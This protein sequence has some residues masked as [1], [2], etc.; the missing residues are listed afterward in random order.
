[1]KANLRIGA[2]ISGGGTNLQAVIDACE[3]HTVSGQVVFVGADNPQAKGLERAKRHGI[4]SFV[5]DYGAILAS[6][7]HD[8]SRASLPAD[9]DGDALRA[10]CR[11]FPAQTDPDRI[12]RFLATRAM[13]EMIAAGG[14]ARVQR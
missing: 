12:R 14:G 1:M 7:R 6:Y 2:L 4:P 3:N 11:L 10:K 8:P 9:F 13:A 5:V